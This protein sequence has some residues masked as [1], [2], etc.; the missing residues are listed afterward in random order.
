MDNP[1]SRGDHDPYRNNPFVLV[2]VPT[3]CSNAKI[4]ARHLR[5]AKDALGAERAPEVSW[6]T[7]VLNDPNRRIVFSLL[8]H[9]PRNGKF[10]HPRELSSALRALVSNL[11]PAPPLELSSASLGRLTP[12][13]RAKDLPDVPPTPLGRR[14]APALR[15][16]IRR[17]A[18]ENTR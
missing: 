8:G 2:R 7:D 17:Y 1:F 9:A 10:E 12:P 16:A 15:W 13:E 6:A 5:Q 18:L 11:A 3:D 14:F 4:I